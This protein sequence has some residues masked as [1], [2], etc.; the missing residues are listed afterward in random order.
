MS[1]NLHH[2]KNC[3]QGRALR[4]G[5]PMTFSRCVELA[6]AQEA[7]GGLK[8][9]HVQARVRGLVLCGLVVQVMP[10]RAGAPSFVQLDTEL[11]SLWVAAGRTRSC[12]GVDGRCHCAA[13]EAGRACEARGRLG[14]A[15]LG[16][17]GV[18]L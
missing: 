8:P 3:A 11:G 7:R 6:Q 16:N 18:T 4:R 13:A 9:I 10:E 5:R 12:S 1:W 15:P 17:T 14:A 2:W